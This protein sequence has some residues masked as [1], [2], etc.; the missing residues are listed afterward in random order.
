MQVEIAGMGAKVEVRDAESGGRGTVGQ[1]LVFARDQQE[2]SGEQRDR[3]HD[4]QRGQDAAHPT[5]VKAENGKRTGCEV[6]TQLRCNQES[7]DD[8]EYVYP[9]EAAGQFEPVMIGKNR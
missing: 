6:V 3:Q 7:A 5:I 4:N 8:K 1:R 2:F 9:G